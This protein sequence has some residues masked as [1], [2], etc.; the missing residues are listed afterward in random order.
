MNVVQITVFGANE[1]LTFVVVVET[2]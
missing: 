2:V 1:L